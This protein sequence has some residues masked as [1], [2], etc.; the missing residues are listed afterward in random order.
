MDSWIPLIFIVLAVAMA[1]GPVLMLKPNKYLQRLA[2]LR[3]KALSLGLRVHMLPLEGESEQV[4]AYC[5]QWDK[6]DADRKPWLLR[7]TSYAHE[8]NFYNEWAWQKGM[9]ADACWHQK[10]SSILDNAPSQL[11]AIGKGPQGL[12][13]YWN[14]RGGE[15]VLNSIS[16]ILAELSR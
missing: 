11:L 6:K 15:A 7:R 14:E 16:D 5:H 10:I 8:L 4:S 1:V 13:C 2:G 3:T 12:C 9:E